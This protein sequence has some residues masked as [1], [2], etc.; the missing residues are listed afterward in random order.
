MKPKLK[1]AIPNI[2]NNS[3]NINYCSTFRFLKSKPNHN[4]FQIYH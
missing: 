1:F 3:A 2:D 4:Y